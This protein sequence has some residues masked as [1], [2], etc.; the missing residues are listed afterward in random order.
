M[1]GFSQLE[2]NNKMNSSCEFLT[3]VNHIKYPS[4]KKFKGKI[5]HSIINVYLI[6][7]MDISSFCISICIGIKNREKE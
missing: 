5:Q 2:L 3:N 4:P 1:K 7:N 6:C